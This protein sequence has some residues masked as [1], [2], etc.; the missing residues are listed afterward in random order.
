M[1]ETRAKMWFQHNIYFLLGRTETHQH[2]ARCHGV[3]R[4]SSVQS[5]SAAWTTTVAAQADRARQQWVTRVQ[6]GGALEAA[7]VGGV[8]LGY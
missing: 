2:R 6:A 5:S 1:L 7:A 3:A 4:R 8:S